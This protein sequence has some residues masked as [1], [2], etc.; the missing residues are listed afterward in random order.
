MNN[1]SENEN[2]ADTDK[3]TIVG[4]VERIVFFNKENQYTVAVITEEKNEMEKTIVG[5]FTSIAPG[6]TMRLQGKTVTN[7]RYGS[8]F[9]VETYESI[10]PS[11]LNAIRKYLGSGLIKGIGETFADRIVEK[12][13]AD[14]LEVI[15]KDINRLREIEGVGKKRIECIKVAWTEQRDIREIMIFLQ[16]CCVGST[17]AV[18]IYKQYGNESI[19]ILKENP[20]KMAMDIMGIGFK[21]ADSIAQKMGI[22]FNSAVRIEAG[23]IFVLHEFANEGNVF[24]PSEELIIRCKK[25]LG[26]ESEDIEKAITE[27]SNNN[28]IV[29]EDVESNP[30]Y[31]KIFYLAECS[32]CQKLI[33]I[34]NFRGHFP[35]I[36]IDKAI[37]WVASRL[38]IELSKKQELA[39]RVVIENKVTVVTGGPG[40]GKTT[41]I[42]SIIKILEAKRNRILLAAPTG[43]AAKRLS[44]TTGRNAMTIHRL[45]KFNA[46]KRIFE[47]NE[48]NPMEADVFVVDEVSMI[49]ITLMNHLLR[50]IPLNAKLVLVG[51]TDQLPSV[52]PGNVLKDIIDSGFVHTI[53]LTEIFRQSQTSL[54]VENAHRINNGEL[55]I[56][57]EKS[58]FAGGNTASNSNGK[59]NELSDFF[60]LENDEPKKIAETI[61]Y[62]CKHE[63][64][65]KFGFDPIKDVQVLTP[66]H[67]GDVGATAL[68]YELQN[69]LNPQQNSDG[70]SSLRFCENDKVMQIKNN[71]EKDV[72]NG[73]AGKI[74]E[75]DKTT[76]DIKVNFE[77]RCVE[78]GITELDE[79]VLSYAITIHKSQ[80]NEYPVVIIPISTQHYIMLQRNLIYTAITRGKKLVILVGSK[81]AMKMAVENN[82]INN[83]YT[84]L[85]D[86]LK[87]A[88]N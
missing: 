9:K 62:L 45:L 64:P 7:K 30:V 55:P 67:K 6:E 37:E 14:T 20:Y 88:T 71:Y 58:S 2:S 74:L 8:Q 76:G 21:T 84:R 3:E 75:V 24:A 29:K 80:G 43:R 25:M 32:V 52:G 26:V 15:D 60:F 54:I 46:G 73:D 19:T 35:S 13:G 69:E 23:I 50:A 70:N 48:K 1:Y 56:Q 33:Q 85:S 77:G 79:L 42:N 38:S 81:K 41:I 17:N 31:L 34:V 4:I 53:K 83:R 39:I 61:K 72:Y 68:N 87:I 18:K 27:L 86:R 63:I 82:S 5:N 57:P 51:D 11:T 65:K 47:F 22:P 49:D 28:L 78:Y 40:V 44:E 12:F 10:V 36:I 59:N 16:G 66:M